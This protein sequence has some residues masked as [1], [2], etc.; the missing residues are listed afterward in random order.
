VSAYHG[1]Q[2]KAAIKEKIGAH[3]FQVNCRQSRF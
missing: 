3:S 2:G 1:E